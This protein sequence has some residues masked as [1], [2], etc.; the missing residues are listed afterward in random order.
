MK[1]FRGHKVEDVLRQA[2]VE[3]AKKEAEEIREI[4]EAAFVEASG[5]DRETLHRAVAVLDGRKAA[6]SAGIARIR[7][8]VSSARTAVMFGVLDALLAVPAV[9]RRVQ[10][11]PMGVVSTIWVLWIGISYLYFNPDLLPEAR[12]WHGASQPDVEEPYADERSSQ[13][14]RCRLAVWD[15][16]DFMIRIERVYETR[17]VCSLR[18]DPEMVPYG[19]DVYFV[20]SFDCSPFGR[21]KPG[22]DIVVGPILAEDGYHGVRARTLDGDSV[23]NFTVSTRPCSDY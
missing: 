9:F 18:E 12:Y 19:S 14:D 7:S 5:L 17:F 13:V 3:N 23:V 20:G 21:P 15:V 6:R 4:E 10:K 16:D 11:N 8:A 1:Y 22:A 2:A